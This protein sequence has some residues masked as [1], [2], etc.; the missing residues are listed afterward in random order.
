[1]SVWKKYK[2]SRAIKIELEELDKSLDG[3]WVKA[4]PTTANEPAKAMEIEKIGS[5]ESL[6]SVAQNRKI[7]EFW[8]LDW[9]L[10]YADNEEK[11]LPPPSDNNHDWENNIP[12]DVQL[13]IMKKIQEED[14][15]RIDIPKENEVE[16]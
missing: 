8:I 15:K 14:Q 12:F 5:D 13:F 4:L 16:S 3:L 7:M 10:P 6:D 1:M 11:I 2:A 9:N